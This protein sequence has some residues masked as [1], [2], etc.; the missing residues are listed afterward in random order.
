MHAS[1]ASGRLNA[2]DLRPSPQKHL[3]PSSRLCNAHVLRHLLQPRGRRSQGNTVQPQSDSRAHTTYKTTSCECCAT[4]LVL[5]SQAPHLCCV[6]QPIVRD[7]ASCC[8]RME[9]GPTRP[10]QPG[11]SACCSPCRVQQLYQS[12]KKKNTYASLCASAVPERPWAGA[13]AFI[14]RAVQGDADQEDASVCLPPTAGNVA[15]TQADSP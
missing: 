8:E 4:A 10:H 5:T 2:L 6:M 14:E 1:G 15:S 12:R 7:W 9:D 13:G 3:A 11:D